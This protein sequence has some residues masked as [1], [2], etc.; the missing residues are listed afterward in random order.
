LMGCRRST[1]LILIMSLMIGRV[2]M[3]H[4]CLS[5]FVCLDLD[6]GVCL[7]ENFQIPVNHEIL[8]L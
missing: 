8:I 6:H 2:M 3:K 5:L 1:I 4:T 7:P